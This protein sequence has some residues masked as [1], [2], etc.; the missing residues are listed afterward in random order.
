TFNY[1]IRAAYLA[2]IPF[3]VIIGEREIQNNNLHVRQYNNP[4]K[5]N[6]SMIDFVKMLTDLI[7]NKS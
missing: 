3:Q 2:K 7:K 4:G 1:K 5:R 6:M